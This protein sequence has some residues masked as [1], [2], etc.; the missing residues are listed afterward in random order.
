MAPDELIAEGIRSAEGE[1]E[2]DGEGG[3][4]RCE[5]GAEGIGSASDGDFAGSEI[6][7]MFPDL[8]RISR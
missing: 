8:Y 6:L 3:V 7:T 4:S 2:G 1:F 5:S